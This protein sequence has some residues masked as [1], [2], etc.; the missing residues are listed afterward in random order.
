MFCMLRE[1]EIVVISRDPMIVGIVA[2]GD[3][4]GEKYY[5][6]PHFDLFYIKFFNSLSI[7]DYSFLL[8]AFN[9]PTAPT[10]GN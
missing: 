8:E 3:W 6:F 4:E 7:F 9:F 2:A 1:E 10:K 5:F